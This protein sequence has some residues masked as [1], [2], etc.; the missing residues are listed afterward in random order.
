[1]SQK[2]KNILRILLILDLSLESA[3]YREWHG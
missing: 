3:K 1:M 2:N